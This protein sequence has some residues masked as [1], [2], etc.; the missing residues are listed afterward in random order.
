M[1]SNISTP[2]GLLEALSMMGNTLNE[3]VTENEKL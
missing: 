3:L 1:P 2:E